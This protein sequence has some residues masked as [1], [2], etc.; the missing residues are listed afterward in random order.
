MII[1]FIKHKDPENRYDVSNVEYSLEVDTLNEI[2][3][4][5]K[6]FLKGC[7]FYESQIKKVFNEEDET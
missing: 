7:G 3:D 6:Y 1:K 4:E 2:V 5:F